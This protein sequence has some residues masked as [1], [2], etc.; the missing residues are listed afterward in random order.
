MAFSLE[1]R[2]QVALRAD[3]RCEYCKEPDIVC[4]FPYHIDH[5]IS[6]KHGGVDDLSNL[7]YSCPDCNIYKGSNIATLVADKLTRLYNPR[8]DVWNEHFVFED[9]RISGVSDIGVGTISVLR[10]N[11]A[12]RVL[13]RKL[14]QSI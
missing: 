8:R 11:L 7:A 1:I 2:S 9:F 5:I 10:F 3:Y 14:G 4:A 6:V 13:D 12:S